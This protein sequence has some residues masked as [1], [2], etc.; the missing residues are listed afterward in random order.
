[1]WRPAAPLPKHAQIPSRGAAAP[2]HR[3]KRGPGLARD[4]GSREECPRQPVP[5]PTSAN[6]VTARPTQQVATTRAAGSRR[7]NWSGSGRFSD[8][9]N[10]RRLPAA[11]AG[12]HGRQARRTRLTAIPFLP[13]LLPRKGSTNPQPRPVGVPLRQPPGMAHQTTGTSG[14]REGVAGYRR[15]SR[16]GC[17]PA[18]STTATRTP[19]V[20]NRW[21]G[22]VLLAPLPAGSRDQP[23]QR[24]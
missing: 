19:S 3:G 24:P 1:M 18:P 16:T 11:R 12:T 4:G 2:V 13:C 20:R 21:R 15:C 9:R 17:T 5:A 14:E 7:Q 22:S 6:T 10:G 23:A 8:D